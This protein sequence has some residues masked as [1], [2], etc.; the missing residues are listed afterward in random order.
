MKDT[1][2]IIGIDLGTTHCVLSYTEAQIKEDSDVPNINIFEIPQVIAQGEIKSQPLLP[3]FLFLPGEHDVP[4][5][6]LAVPWD[7]EID[8]T[9]GEFARQ[10]GAEIPNRLVSSSKSWLCHSSIDRTKPI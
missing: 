2:Y 3:S 10:R 7:R 6:S 5:G 8:C 1:K 4:E 9:V